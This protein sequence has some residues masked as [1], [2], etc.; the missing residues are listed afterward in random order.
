REGIVS[1]TAELQ[2]A[3]GNVATLENELR[4]RKAIIVGTE[5]KLRVVRD[6]LAAQPEVVKR[7]QQLE[8]NP[9]V[10][11]LR[12]QLVDREVDQ[13]AMLRKYTENDR[14]VRDNQTEI[15]ELSAKPTRES[16]NE[17]MSVSSETFAPNPV[18]E[19][20]LAALL[21]LEAKLRE[22]RAR[23]IALEEDLSRERRQLVDLKQR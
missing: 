10:K 8:V 4:S 14:H 6:Q 13:V 3:V 5:E 12:E 22:N 18:Y 21:D 17:P 20:R 7:V 9:V 1:P 23:M 2:A 19:T 15:R 16:V 11:Q